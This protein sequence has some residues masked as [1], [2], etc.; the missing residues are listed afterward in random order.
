[1]IPDARWIQPEPGPPA[2]RTV[3][4]SGK[5]AGPETA[6]TTKQPLALLTRWQGK[7]RF[8]TFNCAAARAPSAQILR[9]C[10]YSAHHH[11]QIP[12]SPAGFVAR[13]S[14]R[15][16]ASGR[17]GEES[18]P[19]LHHPARKPT[20]SSIQFAATTTQF[21]FPPRT[22]DLAGLLRGRRERSRGAGEGNATPPSCCET[23]EHEPAVIRATRFVQ[24]EK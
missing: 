13:R 6:T 16:F 17:Q 12:A 14:I 8:K 22:V 2:A 21:M 4:V 5:R 18:P 1:M 3:A 9:L 10:G 20:T 15:E 7:W 19:P 23:N 11:L 24:T